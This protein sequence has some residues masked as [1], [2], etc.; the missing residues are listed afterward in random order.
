MLDL[1]SEFVQCSFLAQ[2]WAP[3]IVVAI[4]Q[5]KVFRV[6]PTQML[7][8]IMHHAASIA[9][10][11]RGGSESWDLPPEQGLTQAGIIYRSGW[12][13]PRFM[14]WNLI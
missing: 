13:L 10:L 2:S 9:E 14:I 1:F 8:L 12:L 4:E 7:G 3:L 11:G 5:L 6:L